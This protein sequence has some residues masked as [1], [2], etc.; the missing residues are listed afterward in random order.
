MVW[1]RC[2]LINC[3]FLIQL[4]SEKN[5]SGANLPW[6]QMFPTAPSA[7]TEGERGIRRRSNCGFPIYKILPLQNTSSLPSSD[8][9]FTVFRS[10]YL[11]EQTASRVATENKA[12]W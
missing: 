3:H 12:P 10:L 5:E 4:I 8:R 1:T 7:E 9:S 2:L 6:F 11:F